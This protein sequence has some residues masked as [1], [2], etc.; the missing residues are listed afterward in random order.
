[1][2]MKRLSAPTHVVVLLKDADARAAEILQRRLESELQSMPGLGCQ[3]C[4]VSLVVAVRKGVNASL[5]IPV[6]NFPDSTLAAVSTVLAAECRSLGVCKNIS[7]MSLAP[8]TPNRQALLAYA[9]L[10]LLGA[11]SAVY[12][13]VIWVAKE[14]HTS[15]FRR[16]TFLAPAAVAIAT[17]IT[18]TAVSSLAD[19]SAMNGSSTSKDVLSSLPMFLVISPVL[20][21]LFFR[22]WMLRRAAMELR[23]IPIIGLSIVGFVLSHALGDADTSFLNTMVGALQL[24]ILGCGLT[25][26]WLKE[27]SL[28]SCLVAHAA[29]NALAMLSR[30]V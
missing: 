26:L 18:A 15:T 14:R 11:V 10:V 12:I 27:R 24:T 9:A 22:A 2:A 5:L 3:G 1:M 13:L 25:W 19:G 16:P 7:S 30:Y 29:Y 20:E 21:E 4:Q 8:M 28:L 23:S 17:W 6:S